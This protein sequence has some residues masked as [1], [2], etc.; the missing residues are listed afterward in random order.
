MIVT[1]STK[2]NLQISFS[3]SLFSLWY[4]VRSCF[5]TICNKR[6]Y[7]LG[8]ILNNR[9]YS[10]HCQYLL[11]LNLFLASKCWEHF[12]T[13]CFSPCLNLPGWQYAYTVQWSS[14][15]FLFF[16]FTMPTTPLHD[17]CSL[18]NGQMI[19]YLYFIPILSCFSHQW[20][21][22]WQGLKQPSTQCHTATRWWHCRYCSSC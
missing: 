22:I 12:A 14:F 9:Q 10:R 7:S 1:V 16:F 11:N 19:R 6:V 3:L 8:K 21:N 18:E 15:F 13:L 17:T 5:L 20:T 2:N 4:L